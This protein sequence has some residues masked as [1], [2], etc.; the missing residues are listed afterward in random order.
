M[1]VP[2][3]SIVDITD[4]RYLSFASSHAVS[5]WTRNPYE[6]DT[7]VADSLPHSPSGGDEILVRSAGPNKRFDD[8]WEKGFD[9]LIK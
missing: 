4:R 9:D 1:F 6:T 2:E 3:H 8:S 7:K 5:F